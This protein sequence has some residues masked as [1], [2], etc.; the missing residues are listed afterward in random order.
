[1][2]DRFSRGLLAGIIA[3][4]ITK[5]YDLTAFYL[6]LS[7]LRWFDFTATMIYGH[8]PLNLG[9]QIFATLGTWFFHSMLGIIFVFM[10]ERL[11]SSDNLFLKGWFYGVAWWF[12]IC[13]IFQLFK[14]PEFSNIPLKTTLSNFVGASIW[15][16]LLAAAVMWLN[17]QRQG[18]P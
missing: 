10:I 2:K 12:I 3:G 9:E 15:G 13:V 17:R 5:V 14:I 1:M 7:T 8:K 11:F 16:I 4:V 6:H 18:T